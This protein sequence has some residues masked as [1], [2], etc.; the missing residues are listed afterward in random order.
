MNRVLVVDDEPAMRA[1]LEA[2]FTRHGWEVTTASGTREAMERFRSSPCPLV[3]TDMRMPDGDGLGVMQ[4]VRALAPDTAVIFL[5][6]FGNV[7]EAVLAMQQGAC[8]YLVKPV[9]FE[10]LRQAAARVLG[11]SVQGTKGPP[12]SGMVGHSASLRGV[13]ERA[14]QVAKSDADVLIMA[15]SGTGKELLAQFIHRSSTRRDYPFV[16]VNCAAFPEALLESE[17]FGHVR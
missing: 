2:N 5:T 17:L 8:D 4:H 6:A 9:S 15:E 13:M 3:I 11:N 16:A 10:Q 7:P 14:C 12:P 1:A